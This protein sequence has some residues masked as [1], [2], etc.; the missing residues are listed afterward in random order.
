MDFGL[1]SVLPP[2]R[3]P[4]QDPDNLAKPLMDTLFRPAFTQAPNPAA[5]TSAL[6]DSHDG[7]VFSLAVSKV[8]VSDL[9]EAGIDLQAR[10]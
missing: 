1:G 4:A 2:Q 7:M 9:A 10:W 5:V 6:S 8:G 3:A